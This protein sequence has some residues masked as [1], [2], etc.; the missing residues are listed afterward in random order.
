M[1]HNETNTDSLSENC[2]LLLFGCVP[3]A[4]Q[5]KCQL[6]R[7]ILLTA[8]LAAAFVLCG[9][10]R[11]A[12]QSFP[13]PATNDESCFGV[14]FNG[15]TLAGWEGDLTYWRVE[16]GCLV[17]EVTPET[18]LKQNSFIIWRGGTI[19]DFELKVEYRISSKGNSGINYRSIEL[20]GEKWAM[21]GYQADIEGFDRWTGQ[22]YEERGRGFLALCGQ[23]TQVQE[24]KKSRLV[25]S[26]GDSK[27][28]QSFVNKEDWN[29]Y[30]L[31]TRGNTLIHVLNG[32][33]LSVLI[34]DDAKNRRLEGLLG[35][36]VHVGP[37]MKIEYRNIRLKR[38]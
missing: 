28:L 2:R 21:R 38:L 17:G 3:G 11:A 31:I 12:G 10:S 16:N 4:G 36:Q 25:A 29:H 24:G 23:M 5:S 8:A 9:R 26:L 18:L 1:K 6:A 34:D 22:N 15:K 30:H 35:V 32:H 20:P 13:D 37:P 27:E 7:R 33:V 19:G 14:I